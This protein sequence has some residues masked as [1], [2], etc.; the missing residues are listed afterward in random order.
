MWNETSPL[1]HNIK[2]VITI[3]HKLNRI[4]KTIGENSNISRNIQ[5]KTRQ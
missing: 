5:G 3:L 2:N 1:N 4:E